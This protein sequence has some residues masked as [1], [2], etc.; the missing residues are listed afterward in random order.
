VKT[1][2]AIFAVLLTVTNLSA[3]ADPPVDLPAAARAANHV[4]VATVTTIES[5]FDENEF[6]DRLIV[7]RVAFR[8]DE[9]LKGQRETTGVIILEG[10]TVGDLTLR[11]SDMPQMER[12][13]RA[14]LFMNPSTKGGH[15][16]YG[17]GRGVMKL[18]TDNR[19][20]GTALTIDDI[21][22]AVRQAQ[23]QGS[24]R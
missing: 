20:V 10:G 23:G 22:A 19:V 18:D 2:S 17:R 4:V 5:A 9:T 24:G 6:G 12:G 8:V 15:V 16:P 7:S 13:Q 3:A 21:K 1:P 11:V 14:V